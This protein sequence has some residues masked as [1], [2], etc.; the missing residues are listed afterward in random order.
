MQNATASRRSRR[1]RTSSAFFMLKNRDI[2]MERQGRTIKPV[3]VGIRAPRYRK[4]FP[5]HETAQRVI[6]DRLA[7]NFEI[8]FQRSLETSHYKGKWR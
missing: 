7:V 8:A 1:S 6:D 5:F 4:R 2:V 3:L